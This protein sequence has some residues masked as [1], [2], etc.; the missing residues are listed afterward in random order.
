MEK[1]QVQKV[2]LLVLLPI[3]ALG[4]IYRLVVGI[5]QKQPTAVFA[6]KQKQEEYIKTKAEMLEELKSKVEKVEYKADKFLDPL[7]NKLAF[8]I[9]KVAEVIPKVKKEIKQDISPPQLSI[10]GLVWNSDRPQAIVNGRVLSVGD[11]I[12]GTRLLSV[13]KDGIKVG[14]KGI[15][16]FIKK[17]K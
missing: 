7:K 12:N 9:A 13:N 8:Y 2:I 3:L 14:Y 6:V 1:T 10:A 11:E 15:E 17:T 5:R 4:L 16:F